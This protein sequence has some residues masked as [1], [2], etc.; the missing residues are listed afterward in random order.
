MPSVWNREIVTSGQ[1]LTFSAALFLFF[2]FG[3]ALILQPG[4]RPLTWACA[5]LAIA[6]AIASLIK[7]RPRS[8]IPD[9]LICGLGI[10]LFF[11]S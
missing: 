10:I 6:F 4:M 2:A 9:L 5:A 3:S 7:N 1:Q 11:I 8:A